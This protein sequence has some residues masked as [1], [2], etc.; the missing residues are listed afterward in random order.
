MVIMDLWG[1]AYHAMGVIGL[2]PALLF[3]STWACCVICGWKANFMKMNIVG[4]CSFGLAYFE[5]YEVNEPNLP[6]ETYSH[7]SL[8]ECA[9]CGV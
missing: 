9:A 4:Y 8:L 7:Y 2:I 5:K 6:M 3:I 1:M